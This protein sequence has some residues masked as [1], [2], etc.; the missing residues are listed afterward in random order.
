MVPISHTSGGTLP[1][2]SQQLY[3]KMKAHLGIGASQRRHHSYNQEK[4]QQ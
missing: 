3:S 2:S 1:V 4:E